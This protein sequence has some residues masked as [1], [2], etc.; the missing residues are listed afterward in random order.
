MWDLYCMYSYSLIAVMEV[1][2]F[3]AVSLEQKAGSTV[4]SGL[5]DLIESLCNI[6]GAEEKS[7]CDCGSGAV[8][9]GW[10]IVH[11]PRD[12]LP[13][14]WIACWGFLTLKDSNT[15]R[16]SVTSLTVCPSVLENV[17]TNQ[18][19][20]DLIIDCYKHYYQFK[21]INPGYKVDKALRLSMISYNTVWQSHKYNIY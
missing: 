18:G 3:H 19:E 15:R 6:S 13:A 14:G 10:C 11:K 5:T 7:L 9:C 2:W 12:F 17:S 21:N 20:L 1:V 8:I 16:T 4:S